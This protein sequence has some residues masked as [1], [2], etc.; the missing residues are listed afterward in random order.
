[1]IGESATRSISQILFSQVL[2]ITLFSGKCYAFA[3]PLYEPQQNC[4]KVLA[5]PKPILLS[6]S[7]MF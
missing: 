5:G 7:Y 4:A 6:Q 3:V 1:M 2:F